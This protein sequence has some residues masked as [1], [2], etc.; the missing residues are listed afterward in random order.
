MSLGLLAIV[1][2]LNIHAMV[3]HKRYCG[4]RGQGNAFIRR[5]QKNIELNSRIDNTVGVATAHDSQRAASGK[6]PGIKEVR[7]NTAGLERKL[8]KFEHISVASEL[9]KFSLVR[10]H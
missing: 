6:L 3:V 2:K 7:A 8:A 4:S 5:P 9:Y 10:L 1:G